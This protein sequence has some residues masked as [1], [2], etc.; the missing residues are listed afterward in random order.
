MCRSVRHLVYRLIQGVLINQL[1]S[2]VHQ[3]LS[4]TCIHLHTK[5]F[6][7]YFV[8]THF[9]MTFFTLNQELVKHTFRAIS[10]STAITGTSLIDDDVVDGLVS[11]WCVVLLKNRVDDNLVVTLTPDCVHRVSTKFSCVCQLLK[12]NFLSIVC[13]IFQHLNDVKKNITCRKERHLF[14]YATLLLWKN[15]QLRN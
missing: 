11:C 13:N 8:E 3:T 12:T 1:N 7:L 10:I 4:Y 6:Y 9:Y 2:Q 14:N 15:I 5:T